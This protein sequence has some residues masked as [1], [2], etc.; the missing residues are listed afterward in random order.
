MSVAAEGPAEWETSKENTAPLARGR[1]VA[2][3]RSFPSNDNDDAVALQQRQNQEQEQQQKQQRKQVVEY[4]RILASHSSNETEDPLVDWLSY[5]Q[6]HQTVLCQGITNPH[7]TFLLMEQCFLA[8]HRDPRYRNDIRFIRVCCLYADQTPEPCETFARLHHPSLGIGHHT[9]LFYTAWAYCAE[10]EGRFDEA[11][12]ILRTGLHP[13]YMAQPHALLQTRHARFQRRWRRH[14][15]NSSN[16]TNNNNNNESYSSEATSANVATAMDQTSLDSSRR[17]IFGSLTSTVYRH[18]PHP[19]PNAFRHPD[20]S[21]SILRNNNSSR[22]ASRS[23]QPAA[24]DTIT[25]NNNNNIQPARTTTT[26]PTGMGFGIFTDAATSSPRLI[27]AAPSSPPEQGAAEQYYWPTVAEQRKENSATAQ[28]W[29]AHGGGLTTMAIDSASVAPQHQP[30]AATTM[31]VPPSFAIFSDPTDLAAEQHQQEQADQESLRHRRARDDRSSRHISSNKSSIAMAPL[32]TTQDQRKPKA[33]SARC[34]CYKSDLV[35]TKGE[36]GEEQSLEEARALAHWSV[37]IP[38]STTTTAS[39]S[40]RNINRFLEHRIKKLTP[41]RDPTSARRSLHHSI[42]DLSQINCHAQEEAH[43]A[44]VVPLLPTP[45]N[46]SIGISAA[47]AVNSVDSSVVGSL[48]YRRSSKEEEEEQTIN[49]QLALREL[50]VMFYSPAIF[51]TTTTGKAQNT[52]PL[53]TG[54]LGPILNESASSDLRNCSILEEREDEDDQDDGRGC[55][56]IID[57]CTFNL[58]PLVSSSFAIHNDADGDMADNDFQLQT[59]LDEQKDFALAH[60]TS[61]E[62]PHHAAFNSNVIAGNQLNFA[63]FQESSDNSLT[64]AHDVS[65]SKCHDRTMDEI[66]KNPPSPLP[67]EGDTA[68]YSL[69]AA[70][71]HD[72]NGDASDHITVGVKQSKDLCREVDTLVLPEWKSRTSSDTLS[73]STV[74]LPKNRVQIES[75]RSRHNSGSPLNTCQGMSAS[76]VTKFGSGFSI[77]N[78]SVDN[79]NTE[80]MHPDPFAPVSNPDT[81]SSLSEKSPIQRKDEEVDNA[82][83]G[84]NSEEGDTA[85]YAQVSALLRDMKVDPNGFKPAIVNTQ[86]YSKHCDSES[87]SPNDATATA[88]VDWKQILYDETR[89]CSPTDVKTGT[90]E[91]TSNPLQ[92]P[93]RVGENDT[94][95]QIY[96]DGD[97]TTTSLLTSPENN[98]RA[99]AAQ[100]YLRSF[101]DYTD[102]LGMYYI[103]VYS[104]IRLCFLNDSYILILALQD[105]PPQRLYSSDDSSLAAILDPLRPLGMMIF[106]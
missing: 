51:P 35:W 11:D 22:T 72:L 70:L 62:L 71:L 23:L 28:P 39:S 15:I 32:P 27:P 1:R 42:E 94:Q 10:K 91:S 37:P 97:N 68:T 47:S 86:P 60:A 48:G 89:D 55:N 19:Q 53:R 5:I 4:Q 12:A 67:A 38:G 84:N 34:C 96:N 102:E 21:L 20:P 100:R 66:T 26:N 90:N 57:P 93:N 43:I 80:K 3:P 75:G 16:T 41:T 79:N 54:G 18:Q 76:V 6:Y 56:S 74:I 88:I 24:A 52:A 36:S 98:D 103:H 50:S 63:I 92:R 31:L 87:S 44:L 58:G 64:S 7:S 95:F 49:T 17:G 105:L 104:S 8:L 65:P 25:N 85:S 78:E 46:S 29:N 9:A 101:C 81:A 61:P 106:R 77:Y 2:A 82:E 83:E 30:A 14:Q 40:S 69:V 33:T 59:R 73:S 45:R 13:P 99:V